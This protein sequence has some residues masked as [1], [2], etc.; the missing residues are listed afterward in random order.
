MVACID[1]PDRLAYRVDTSIAYI[2]FCTSRLR[3]NNLK[4]EMGRMSGRELGEQTR[5]I[6][7]KILEEIVE[8]RALV[9]AGAFTFTRERVMSD[10]IGGL[11]GGRGDSDDREK[12]AG[13]EPRFS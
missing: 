10:R 9:S 5:E 3:I 4:Y 6:L 7:E 11:A 2:G 12:P 8:I 13:R 1:D